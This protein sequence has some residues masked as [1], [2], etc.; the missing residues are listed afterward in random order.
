[1]PIVQSTVIAD[2]PQVDG[3]RRL[4]EAHTDHLGKAHRYGPVWVSADYDAQTGLTAH[5]AQIEAQ[6]ADV[7]IEANIEE[8]LGAD[9]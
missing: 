3:R 6:L 5:A 8:F 7:E 9:L 4:V 2:A 1:M